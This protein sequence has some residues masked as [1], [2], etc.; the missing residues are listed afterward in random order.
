MHLLYVLL[1]S[2]FLSLIE[3]TNCFAQPKEILLKFICRFEN[4]L[5]INLDLWPPFLH[6]VAFRTYNTLRHF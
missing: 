2:L 5:K 3:R 4:I 1:R 6:F